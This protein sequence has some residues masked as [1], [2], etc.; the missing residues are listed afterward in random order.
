MEPN[1]RGGFKI[2]KTV[3]RIQV[4]EETNIYICMYYIA[5]DRSYLS[6]QWIH[7]KLNF[8]THTVIERENKVDYFIWDDEDCRQNKIHLGRQSS[9]K[10]VD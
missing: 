9:T 4:Q 5:C 8:V 2:I 1:T 10:C 3:K 7:N 6:I